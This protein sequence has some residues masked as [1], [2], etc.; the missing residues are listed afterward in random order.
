MRVDNKQKTVVGRAEEV[1]FPTLNNVSLHARIDTGAKTS[2]IWASEI[3]ELADGKL[4]VRFAAKGYDIYEHEV[5]F[6]S[7][8]QV[9]IASSMGHEQLRYKIQIPVRIA[10]RRIKASFTL[11][12]R[13]TQVYPILIGRSMLHGKFIVDVTQG[14]PLS[15]AE[16]DRSAQLQKNLKPKKG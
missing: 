6:D 2:S 14:D 10:G 3:T 12:D 8:S 4:S 1:F 7:F 11:S 9:R 13:S 15:D 5:I 16:D